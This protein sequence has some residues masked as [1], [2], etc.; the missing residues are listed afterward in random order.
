MRSLQSR[1]TLLDIRKWVAKA[2]LVEKCSSANLEWFKF[3]R[4]VDRGTDEERSIE[5]GF[6][7]LDR[8]PLHP[9]GMFL[10]T[11]ELRPVSK[12]DNSYGTPEQ[13]AKLDS[14]V[15]KE[16][17]VAYTGPRI[18][19]TPPQQT[20][21]LKRG[22][23][24]PLL[25]GRAILADPVSYNSVKSK[26]KPFGNCDA[27]LFGKPW[28][29]PHHK[30]PL[31]KGSKHGL[32][33]GGKSRCQSASA[34][35]RTSERALDT[36]CSFRTGSQPK[37]LSDRKGIAEQLYV[38]NNVVP[39]RPAS[40]R[41]HSLRQIESLKSKAQDIEQRLE[42]ALLSQAVQAPGKTIEQRQSTAKSLISDMVGRLHLEIDGT[43]RYAGAHVSNA[44]APTARRRY[45]RP[46]SGKTH[47]IPI[48]N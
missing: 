25:G 3:L 6:V 43:V 8:E 44:G 11:V 19:S 32:E 16:L 40:A 18:F 46:S 35:L 24:T 37:I 26:I 22:S 27:V 12:A 17:Q 20:E 10:P 29:A 28:T 1:E 21:A 45:F 33:G 30:L 31:A 48:P 39:R 47:R 38:V 41:F 4:F 2:W 14:I 7:S 15:R 36:F 34:L 5:D 9:A 42:Q 13:I 23:T